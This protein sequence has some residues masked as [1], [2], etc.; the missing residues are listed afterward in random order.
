[1]AKCILPQSLAI[2]LNYGSQNCEQHVKNQSYPTRYSTLHKIAKLESQKFALILINIKVAS[3]VSCNV[4]IYYFSAA[5]TPMASQTSESATN[6]QAYFDLLRS[7]F[8]DISIPVRSQRYFCTYAYQ[9]IWF[10]F[11]LFFE[12]KYCSSE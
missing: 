5:I 10:W 12:L 9:A 8:M 1:M 2:I 7:I 11:V 6:L 4:P 3:S